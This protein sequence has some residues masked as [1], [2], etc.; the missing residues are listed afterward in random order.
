[1][2]QF[3][4]DSALL[5]LNAK[6]AKRPLS[7]LPPNSRKHEAANDAPSGMY[8]VDD[9]LTTVGILPFRS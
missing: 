3:A 4:S 6:P 2:F 1:M 8:V 9:P 7:Q 5:R